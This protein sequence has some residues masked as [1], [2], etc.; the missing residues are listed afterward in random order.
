MFISNWDLFNC[1]GECLSDIDNDGICDELEILGCTDPGYLEFDPIATDDDS[2]C[3]T[4]IVLGC[5]VNTA[6]NYDSIAN[7][8]DNSWHMK[9]VLIS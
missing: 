3:N 9:V 1:N 7:V 6:L 5:T 4:L 8:D 2:S